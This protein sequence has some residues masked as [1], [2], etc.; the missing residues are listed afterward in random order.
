MNTGTTAV[1]AAGSYSS[2]ISFA[3]TRAITVTGV[4]FYKAGG[5]NRTY[6]CTLWNNAGAALATVDVSTTGAGVYTGTFAAPQ[7]ISQE[8][9]GAYTYKV[10][11]WETS[12]SFYTKITTNSPCLLPPAGTAFLASRSI[13][14]KHLGAYAA[15]NAA[16]N[17]EAAAERYPVEPVV[18]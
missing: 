18:A 1:E 3:P 5:T 11:I 17:T 7:N 10:T 14:V 12:G 16:P 9:G 2:G 15:G 8:A 4:R 13:L 6:R